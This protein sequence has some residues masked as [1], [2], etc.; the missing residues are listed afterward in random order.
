M[1]T[2][3][4]NGNNEIFKSFKQDSIFKLPEFVKFISPY[5]APKFD[6]ALLDEFENENEIE[7]KSILNTSSL[8]TQSDINTAYKGVSANIQNKISDIDEITKDIKN[9]ESIYDEE[10]IENVVDDIKNNFPTQTI[11]C[12]LNTSK[13]KYWKLPNQ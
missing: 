11:N 3:L 12:L 2:F 1:N 9:E 10:N 13:A 7:T 5:F 4:I 8:I 6:K